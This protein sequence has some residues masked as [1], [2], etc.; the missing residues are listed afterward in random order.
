MKNINSFVIRRG[1]HLSTS[2]NIA[3]RYDIRHLTVSARTLPLGILPKMTATRLEGA[4]RTP[5]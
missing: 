4:A 5:T 2:G 1:S 3:L